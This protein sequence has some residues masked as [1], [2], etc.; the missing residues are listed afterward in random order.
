MVEEI[1]EGLRYKLTTT[2][3]SEYLLRFLHKDET[4]K[5][6][7][8][9]LVEDMIN[10]ALNRLKFQNKSK[11]SR[12]TEVAIDKLDY[13]LRRLMSRSFRKKRIDD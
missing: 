2:D 9:I 7:E 3:N 10:L 6:I 12:D 8:G 5:V 13:A 11:Y 4:G 1:E